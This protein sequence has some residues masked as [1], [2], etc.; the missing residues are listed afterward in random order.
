MRIKTKFSSS[1]AKMSLGTEPIQNT[2]AGMAEAFIKILSDQGFEIN[3]VE[4]SGGANSN[5]DVDVE[6]IHLRSARSASL[7]LR[8]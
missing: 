2:A 6:T 8:Q 4:S 7:L 5:I 3:A 1:A